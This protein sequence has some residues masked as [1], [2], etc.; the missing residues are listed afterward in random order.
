[1]TKE[2]IREEIA[3]LEAAKPH[4]K[5]EFERQMNYQLGTIDGRLALLRELLGEDQETSEADAKEGEASDPAEA[6]E[7]WVE[8]Q[9]IPVEESP[10][11]PT[12]PPPVRKRGKKRRK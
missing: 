10:A 6:P 1:M 12:S 5:A 8:G 2:K 11:H 7:W 3:A 9:E 4:V